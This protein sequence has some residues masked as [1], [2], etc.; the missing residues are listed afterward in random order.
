MKLINRKEIHKVRYYFLFIP[1]PW[2]LGFL[3]YHKYM[4]WGWHRRGV[5]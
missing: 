4:P 5:D 2:T 1:L 3:L